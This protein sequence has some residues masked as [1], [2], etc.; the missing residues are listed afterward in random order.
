MVKGKI[1]NLAETASV[2]WRIK[3]CYSS[4]LDED[5]KKW[6]H[7]THQGILICGS[8]G[9]QTYKVGF[10]LKEGKVKCCLCGEIN[11]IEVNPTN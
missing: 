2:E 7:E 1:S 11:D 10:N 9:K 8:C 6:T 4:N 5:I 3:H